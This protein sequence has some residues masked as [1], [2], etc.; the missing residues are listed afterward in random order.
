MQRAKKKQGRRPQ[1]ISVM[2]IL[3]QLGAGTDGDLDGTIYL[4]G[5]NSPGTVYKIT[6]DGTLTTLY[7]LC[8]QP[9]CED[10]D[11]PFG[12]LAQATDGSFYGTSWAGVHIT[13]GRFSHSM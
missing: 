1:S 7:N 13:W 12:G 6:P 11:E 2:A 8:K 10:G 4:G 5:T 3:H 9:A